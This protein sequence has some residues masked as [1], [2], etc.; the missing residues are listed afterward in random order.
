MRQGGGRL[1]APGRVWWAGLT[2]GRTLGCVWWV[3]VTGGRPR[4]RLQWL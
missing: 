3:G 4:E 1:V 2:G